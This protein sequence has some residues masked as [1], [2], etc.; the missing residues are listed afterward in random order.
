[1]MLSERKLNW[2]IGMSSK[3]ELQFKKK[4]E[5]LGYVVI[6]YSGRFMFGRK[7]PAVIISNASDFI[8]EMGMKGLKQDNMGFDFVVYTG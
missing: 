4:A 6:E 7:C 5:E 8:A 3:K 2:R 1:M